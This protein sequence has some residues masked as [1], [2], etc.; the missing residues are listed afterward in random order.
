MPASP[1]ICVS[2]NRSEVIDIRGLRTGLWRRRNA[3]LVVLLVVHLLCTEDPLHLVRYSGI[4]VVPSHVIRY[5][6]RLYDKDTY[7]MSGPTSLLHVVSRLEH[8]HP[9]TYTT[10]WCLAICVIWTGSIA[11]MVC[12]GFPSFARSSNNLYSLS[13]SRVD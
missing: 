5:A 3:F 8:A 7:P 12:T 6:S 1:H 9:L 10:S 11:P 2:N 13:A 4:R